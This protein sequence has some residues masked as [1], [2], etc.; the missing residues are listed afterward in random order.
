MA[1]DSFEYEFL[2]RPQIRGRSGQGD[3]YGRTNSRGSLLSQIRRASKRSGSPASAG[4][5]ARYDVGETPWNSRRCVVKSHY[6]SM[7]R[8][9]RL[10]AG[11]HLAYLERDGVER[12]G[13]P[14][15][16]YGPDDTFNSE[17]FAEPVQGEKRQ[18]RFIVSPENAAQIDLHAFTRELVS[19]M[20][21][22]LGRRLVWAA[23]N[24]H[25]TDHPHVHIVVRGVDGAGQEVRI[26]PRYIQHDMRARAQQQLTRELGLRTEFDIARQRSNEVDQERLTSIDRS[27]GELLTPEGRLD[28]RAVAQMRADLR[29]TVLARLATLARLGLATPAPHGSWTLGEDWQR[30]L[31][32]LGVRN[33][34]IKRLHRVAPG[35][36]SRYRFLEPSQLTAAIE[37]VIRG[38]GLHDELTGELFAAVE[39]HAGE[40]HYVRLE[41]QAAEW[42]QDGDVVRIAQTTE[43]W[44]KPTDRVLAKVAE[45]NDGVYDPAAHLRQLEGSEQKVAAP[46]DLVAGNL[47]RLE[48]LERYGLVNRLPDGTWQVPSDLVEQLQAREATHPRHRIR[49]QYAGASLHTQ[50]NYAGPTWLDRQVSRS[51]ERASTGFGAELEA[52]LQARA[53]YLLS[54]GIDTRSPD[55][56][57]RLDATE[58]LLFGRRLASDLGASY[59][60]ATGT[61][62][63]VLV[64]CPPLPSGRAFARVVDE[65]TKRLVLVPSTVETSRFEG[66]EVEVT[67]DANKNVIVRQARRLSR[68]ED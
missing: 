23:V 17:A 49:V 48:R 18:F 25:N 62:R 64:T 46:Q 61:A 63:G 47:N 56:T 22:D 60:P 6:V 38:R 8:G 40:T 10:A 45:R 28:A 35:D 57:R 27:I 50:V 24:H 29:P 13:S 52:G 26:P 20:E 31:M 33:D 3:G 59:D 42:L 21:K 54:L 30:D 32:A 16:L 68:G 4:A 36:P 5:K 43:S 67:V 37:G 14:G 19:Q 11:R 7:A 58:R 55:K 66:R 65:R 15:R 1:N 12:D 9:G 44:I 41:Q 2:F 53:V 39:T 51:P 34:V